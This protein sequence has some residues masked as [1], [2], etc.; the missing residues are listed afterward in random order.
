M[1]V[2][3]IR[4]ATRETQGLG[5]CSLNA[6]GKSQAENL[7]SK[8]VSPHGPLP[9]PT[10][11]I[12]SPKKRARETLKPLG[13][14]SR[15]DVET[16]AR[17]DERHQNETAAEFE[18]RV[19]SVIAEL[20]RPN[21]QARESCIYLCSHLDWIEAFLIHVPSDLSEQEAYAGWSTA[22]FRVFRIDEG[23]WSL[24]QSGAIPSNRS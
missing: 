17:L 12:A 5:D 9:L 21:A 6:A 8:W 7:A 13:L 10:R 24:K 16:D 15:V 11:L 4:H 18:A 2:V 1:K 3:L 20:S 14:G 23:L 22:E 19:K